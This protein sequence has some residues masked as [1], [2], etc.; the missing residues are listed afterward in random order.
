MPLIVFVHH[1]ALGELF[2]ALLESN[3]WRGNIFGSL[4]K[5]VRQLIGDEVLLPLNLEAFD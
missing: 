1:I 5:D 2:E 3:W 4:S